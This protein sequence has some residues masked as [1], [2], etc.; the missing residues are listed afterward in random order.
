MD[1]QRQI[2]RMLSFIK[3]IFA[4]SVVFFCTT[5]FASFVVIEPQ[6][7]DTI[8]VVFIVDNSGSMH[9]YQEHLGNNLALLLDSLLE[10]NVILKVGILNTST[11]KDRLPDG[12]FKLTQ[13]VTGKSKIDILRDSIVSMGTGGD[14]NET[15]FP[16]LLASFV[17]FENKDFYSPENPLYVVILSDSYDQSDI[18]EL[19]LLSELKKLKTDLSLVKLYGIMAIETKNGRP[20]RG[21]EKPPMKV[22]NLVEN[23]NLLEGKVY[24]MCEENWGSFKLD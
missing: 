24:S 4:G 7:Q 9:E 22:L 18:D 19:K 8:E 23:Y 13:D 20:C 17:D 11:G 15:F 16:N 5:T 21:E 10:K 6:P 1:I 2:K 14:G 12:K 3:T